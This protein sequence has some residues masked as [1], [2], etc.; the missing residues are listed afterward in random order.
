MILPMR[1]EQLTQDGVGA[2]VPIAEGGQGLHGP[3]HAL[4][5]GVE[6]GVLLPVLDKIFQ[7]SVKQHSHDDKRKQQPEVL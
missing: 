2:E 6:P 1:A 4:G 5:D 3:P 7:T